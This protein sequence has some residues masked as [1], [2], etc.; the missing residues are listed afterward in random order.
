MPHLHLPHDFLKAGLAFRQEVRQQDL[1]VVT[2]QQGVLIPVKHALL[3]KEKHGH[4]DQRHV[5][6][7]GHPASDLVFRHTELTLG[8]LEGVF[9][10]KPLRFHVSQI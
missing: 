4:H 6:M 9:D 10:E 8:F 7:P 3:G 5:V 2:G 1:D